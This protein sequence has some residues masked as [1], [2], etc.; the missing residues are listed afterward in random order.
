[1]TP[2]KMKAWIIR[3]ILT[4]LIG[5]LILMA[6]GFGAVV[7]Q[8]EPARAKPYS[9]WAY[10][11]ITHWLD[12]GCSGEDV[13]L[14][15]KADPGP[16]KEVA[17][18]VFATPNPRL[19]VLFTFGQSNSANSGQG[20]YEAGTA[21]SNFNIHD[22]KCY[23]TED[24]LLGA[25][26]GKASVW[27]R[28]GDKLVDSGRYDRVLIV[29]FGLGGTA[30]EEWTVGGRLHPRIKFSADRIIAAGIEPTH[31][32][33][34][35][36]EADVFRGTTTASY[37]EMFKEMIHALRSYGVDAPVF[38]AVA[39]ICTNSGSDAVR[40]AQRALPLQI[41]GVFKGPNTD[42]LTDM[43]ERHDSC[44]FSEV[45]LDAH[46]NLWL[47]AISHPQP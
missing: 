17:C 6:F 9:I 14:C 1:M 7:G 41:E 34:H 8:Y 36:G 24:P 30:L 39:S 28:V 37:I 32:L 3:I 33:W 13:T 43:R 2:M 16:R 22:G 47:E 40:E 23:S 15:G 44:H 21:V 27:G 29:T 18:E 5:Y 42:A 46:A 11:I 26:G 45:G 12:V 38:P 19:A 10:T 25:D 4:L 20:H 35:Q 31:V